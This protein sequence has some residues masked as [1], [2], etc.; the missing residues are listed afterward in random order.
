MGGLPQL[1]ASGK[2]DCL[3]APF[4]AEPCGPSRAPRHS[5]EWA[6]QWLLHIPAQRQ[7]QTWTTGCRVVSGSSKP[8]AVGDEKTI[9]LLEALLVRL[10]SMVAQPLPRIY[11][12]CV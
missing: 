11:Q 8:V 10:L 5:Q 2:T 3:P 6:R 9:S 12:A 7:K 4:A 1:Q